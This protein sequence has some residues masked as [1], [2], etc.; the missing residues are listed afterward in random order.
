MAGSAIRMNLM[1][2]IKKNSEIKDFRSKFF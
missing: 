1:S 2:E